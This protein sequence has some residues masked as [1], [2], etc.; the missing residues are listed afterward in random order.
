MLQ[1][2]VDA[3]ALQGIAMPRLAV[4]R[5]EEHLQ[6]LEDVLR[7]VEVRDEEAMLEGPRASLALDGSRA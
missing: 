5:I 1:A 4:A 7:E 3:H 6:P 2:G